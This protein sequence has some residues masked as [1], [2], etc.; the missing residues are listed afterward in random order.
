MRIVASTSI[1]FPRLFSTTGFESVESHGSI[2]VSHDPRTRFLV[3]PGNRSGKLRFVEFQAP[4]D[5]PAT[6]IRHLRYPRQW[7]QNRVRDRESAALA[8]AGHLYARVYTRS[9]ARGRESSL[10][11]KLPE[12]PSSPPPPLSFPFSSPIPLFLL[13][14]SF[15]LSL[16]LSDTGALSHG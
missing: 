14:L 6:I 13:S 9:R 11:F 4:G 3:E 2:R 1:Q 7:I 5:R 12:F 16:C 8:K 15:S 10:D